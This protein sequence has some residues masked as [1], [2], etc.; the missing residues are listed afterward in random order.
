MNE[1]NTQIARPPVDPTISPPQYKLF[2]IIILAALFVLF[3]G[4]AIGY[5]FGKSTPVVK[6]KTLPTISI[7]PIPTATNVPTDTIEDVIVVK[8]TICTN[9][10]LKLQISPPR[11]WSCESGDYSLI[12][13][14]Q[15]FSVTI[16]N[17]GRGG[18]CGA[19]QNEEDKCI[20]SLFYSRSNITINMYKESDTV[21]E[22]F[23]FISQP[24]PV[25]AMTWIDILYKV[26]P[27][28]EPTGAAKQELVNVLDT[29]RPL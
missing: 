26:K 3:I 18:P 8:N 25:E 14:S 27:G 19:P 24:E 11:D 17:L 12:L 7:S 23:G 22:I 6:Q 10:D 1:D 29:I 20:K 5:Y 2:I 13:D 9:A 21:G 4:L 28:T 15:N 16:S